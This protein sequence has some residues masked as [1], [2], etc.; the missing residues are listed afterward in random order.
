VDARRDPLLGE[1]SRV[2]V[3]R[4]ARPLRVDPDDVEVVRVYVAVVPGERLDPVELGDRGVVG[5]NVPLANRAVPRKL[6]ELDERDRSEDVGE[7]GLVAGHRDVVER[8]AGTAHQPQLLDLDSKVAP[9][10]RDQ[11][12]LAG[13]QVLRRV[14]R[15]AGRVRQAAQL[16]AAVR[17]LERMGRVLDDRHAER[18]ERLELARL[19]GQVDGDDRLR[20]RSDRFRH[21]VRIDVEV[22]VSDIGEDR[23]RAAVDDHVRRRGPGDRAGDHLVAGPNPERDER[24]V[25]RRGS[26]GDSEH[27]LGFQVFAQAPLELR[28]AGPGG[29][30]ARADRL[31]DRFDLLLAHGGRLEAEHRLAL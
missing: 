31:G 4:S 11:A 3:A 29:Q 16:A 8:A 7:V 19:S 2:L 17:A 13:R 6:L 28:R 22:R 25:Q 12:A 30:P 5:G 24:Q 1:Q 23:R 20:P 21:L 10:R 18:P 26:G 27:V 14:E 9:V 15:E